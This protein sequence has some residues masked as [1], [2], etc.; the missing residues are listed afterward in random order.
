MKKSLL[1]LVFMLIAGVCF[2]QNPIE[3]GQA[4]IN[5]GVGL[6]SWGI[7]LYGGV[8]YGV[9]KDVTIGGEL[10]Y[11]SYREEYYSYKFRHS[12]FGI[13]ANGNYHFNTLLDIPDNFDL[14]AGL[15]LGYYI[16]S[17]SN[18][19]GNNKYE[20][21][22]ASGVGLGLQIGGR[23]YFNDAFG[24]NLEIGGGSAFTAGKFGVSFRL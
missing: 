7:P 9:H 3:K 18:S 14:Y 21:S 13:S 10:S 6:S 15:N 2:A 24:I 23:Y 8:D 16:W 1:L 22:G 20:G 19:D 5:A 12:I 17:T 11:R 4:Q